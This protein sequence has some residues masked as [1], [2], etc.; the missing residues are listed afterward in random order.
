MSGRLFCLA[1]DGSSV[2][3]ILIAVGIPTAECDLSLVLSIVFSSY[4]YH[5]EPIISL[6]VGNN[7]IDARK[8]G[9]MFFEFERFVKCKS[10]FGGVQYQFLVRITW[11]NTTQDWV[12]TLL[13]L[14]T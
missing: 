13:L 4:Y 5:L 1:R 12:A 8:V 9:D 10:L 7:R 2:S 14:G 3:I 6:I 11:E